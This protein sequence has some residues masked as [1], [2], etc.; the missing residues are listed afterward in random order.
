V[1]KIPRFAFNNLMKKFASD[2]VA[3]LHASTFGSLR[4]CR[5]MKKMTLTLFAIA[6]LML[7]GGRIVAHSV[8]SNSSNTGSVL[9]AADDESTTPDPAGDPDGPGG[10]DGGPDG[11][12]QEGGPGVA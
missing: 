1:K 11:T 12:D 9:Q 10:P 5:T 2:M 4:S 7:A 8:A 6:A 3:Q